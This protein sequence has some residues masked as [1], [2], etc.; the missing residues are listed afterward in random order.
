[1]CGYITEVAEDYLIVILI[2]IVQADVALNVF[3]NI[4][5]VDIDLLNW[6]ILIYRLCFSQVDSNRSL[7][8]DCIDLGQG[9]AHTVLTQSMQVVILPLYS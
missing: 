8:F 7:F 9:L 5:L 3:I 4:V 2:L 1:M 6:V